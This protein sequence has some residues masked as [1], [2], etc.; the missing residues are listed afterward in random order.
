[1]RDIGLL[2]LVSLSNGPKHGYAIQ[3]DIN[4]FAGLRLGPGT[5]YGAIARLE[6]DGAVEALGEDDRRRPYKLT[7]SGRAQ[8]ADALGL[9]DRILQRAAP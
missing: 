7:R 8:L 6:R 2:V 1:M 4:S 9:F 5:L 3:S